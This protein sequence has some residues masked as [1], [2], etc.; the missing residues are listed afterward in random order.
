MS[1]QSF[2]HQFRRKCSQKSTLCACCR[3]ICDVCSGQHLETCTGLPILAPK[4]LRVYQI[5]AEH[6]GKIDENKKEIMM[7]REEIKCAKHDVE[8]KRSDEK[9]GL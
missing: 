9:F 3:F 5:Y 6:W 2:Y 7:L 4:P 8:M 1:C